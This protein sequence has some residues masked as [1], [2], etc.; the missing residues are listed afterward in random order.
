MSKS[1]NPSDKQKNIKVYF[2]VFFFNHSA[3]SYQVNFIL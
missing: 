1:T 2:R 3:N